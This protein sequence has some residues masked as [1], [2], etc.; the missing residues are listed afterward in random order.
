MGQKALP[1]PPPPHLPTPQEI[2]DPLKNS[3]PPK[4]SKKLSLRKICY[5]KILQ[6]PKNRGGSY[7]VNYGIGWG[8]SLCRGRH[9]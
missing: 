6:S 4:I 5:F 8:E 7:P 3:S 9:Q 2:Q 1:S